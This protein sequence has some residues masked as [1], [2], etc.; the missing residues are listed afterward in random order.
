MFVNDPF[1]HTAGRGDED[2]CHK[3]GPCQLVN[4]ALF[5]MTY[6]SVGARALSGA[7]PHRGS[8]LISGAPSVRLYYL[9][10]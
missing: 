7:T 10:S 6:L 1:L 4:A 3:M 5:V 2:Y 9:I 8:P